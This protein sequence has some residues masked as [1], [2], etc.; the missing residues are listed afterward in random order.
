MKLARQY[1]A[2]ALELGPNDN[3]VLLLL[4][5]ACGDEGETERARELLE[6]TTRRGGSSFAAHY[7]LGRLFV[8]EQ[9]WPKALR[10]FKRALAS[11]PSPEAHYALGCLYYQ[12]GRDGLSIRYL[13]KA[14]EIDASYGEAFHLLGLVY[15][16]AGNLDAAQ[17]A[18]EKAEVARSVAKGGLKAKGVLGNEP[19]L[20]NT[21]S[22]KRKHL[23]TGR[24]TRLAKALREDAL[25]AFV[26]GKN[27]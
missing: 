20:L 11:K 4:G 7:G 18:F 24:D 19:L 8:A 16:R 13:L 14:V 5:L 23:M 2:R 15:R 12:I 1:L 22:I 9:K 3:H 26:S 17:S 27:G 10:E 21:G 25:K 6:A